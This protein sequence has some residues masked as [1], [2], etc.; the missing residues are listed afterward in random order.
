[1]ITVFFYI[2][3]LPDR[4]GQF[5][6]MVRE[7]TESSRADEGCLD[8][9][10]F[11]RLGTEHE[12]VLYERW[13]DQ[14]ALNAHVAR[15]VSE[16]GPPDDDPSLPDTHPRKRLPR[17]FMDLFSSAEVVRYEPVLAEDSVI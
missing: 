13:R 4:E 14:E 1:M 8:Y 3:V 16:Y 17:T 9:T 5:R 12:F 10:Y 11:A 6:S 7:M 2:T 15:L